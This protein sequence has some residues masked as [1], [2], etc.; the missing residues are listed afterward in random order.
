MS[1]VETESRYFVPGPTWVRP[2]ILNE[3]TRPMVGHRS[4]EFR[5][6][7]K[8][9]LTD[10]KELFV[11]TQNTFVATCSGT[12]LLEASLLNC[13]PRRVLV[14]TCGAFSERWLAIA[15]SLGLEVDHLEHKWGKPVDPQALANHFAGRRHHYDAVTITHNETSTGVLSD[16]ATLAK[17]V[18]DESKDTL[19]LVDAVSSLASAPVLFDAWGLDVCL[20][21]TQKGIAL[22]PG[23]TVFAVSDRAME[24]VSKKHFRGTYFDFLE[25]K[26]NAEK[27][28]PPFTPA[29]SLCFALEKQLDFI[30]RHETLEKRWTRHRQMRDLTIER[31]KRYATLVTELESASVSVSAIEPTSRPAPEIVRGMKQRGFTLGGGYGQWKDETFRI[32]HMGDISIQA[33]N[34]MLDV[35]EEVAAAK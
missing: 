19:V 1:R 15:Q 32:G 35:L 31:T 22:P 3:L 29:V 10:L 14:T 27:E 5:E 20:A 9:I 12:A 33:L 18:R 6:I 11:T 24:R 25:Y 34:S 30:L 23:L 17:V 26:K 4:E 8:K 2:E 7:Y 28:S 16:L 13:V 21:S